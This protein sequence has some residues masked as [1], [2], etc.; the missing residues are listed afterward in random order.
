M[1]SIYTHFSIW[2]RDQRE[3]FVKPPVRKKKE[4]RKQAAKSL[5]GTSA[6]CGEIHMTSLTCRN[7]FREAGIWHNCQVSRSLQGHNP[8]ARHLVSGRR[9]LTQWHPGTLCLLPG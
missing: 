1:F 7:I 9:Q 3:G 8:A 4:Q 6:N 5:I 2:I